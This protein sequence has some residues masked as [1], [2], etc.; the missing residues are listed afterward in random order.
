MKIIGKELIPACDKVFQRIFG[1]SGNEKITERLLSVILNKQIKSITLDTN[2]SLLKGIVD[3]KIGVLDVRAK[4]ETGEDYNIE[5]QMS[6]REDIS[7]RILY[8]WSKLYSNKVKEGNKYDDITPTTCILIANY[9]LK[10]LRGIKEFH[11]KWNLREEKVYNKILTKDIEIHI[12]EIPK[13]LK[14]KINIQENELA[15]WLKFL[16]KPRDKEVIKVAQQVSALQQAINELE[17]LKD[18]PN[19]DIYLIRKEIAILDERSA[20]AAAERKGL[21]KGIRKGRQ[22]GMEKGLQEG[23]YK[24]LQETCIKLLKKNMSIPEIID[25]TGLTEEEIMKI[26]KSM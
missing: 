14:Q 2:K 22:E 16:V 21:K 8:Y 3:D 18:D 20:K 5:M 7:K 6:R 9:N 13:M 17:D 12:L 11:T 23:K 1:I 19:Y 26:K 10:E 4:L 15:A 24:T 25:I